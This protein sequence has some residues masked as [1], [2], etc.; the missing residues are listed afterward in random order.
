MA[1]HNTLS[2]SGTTLEVMVSEH[3]QT[4]EWLSSV[5]AGIEQLWPPFQTQLKTLPALNKLPI[6]SKPW[7]IELT[8][9][10]ND[11]I[12]A[13]NVEHRQQDKPTDVLTFS[14]FSDSTPELASLPE[15]ALGSIFISVSYAQESG[16]PLVPYLLERFFH[17]C[18]HL[19]G[20]H[21]D[22]MDDYH[23]VKG[24]Q[25]DLIQLWTETPCANPR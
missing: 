10:D 7:E 14:L 16:E 22:T 9:V 20:Q 19:L 11:E 3:L 23:L 6:H 1:E 25:T 2:L 4:T 8:F 13:L 5:L 15:I 12:Q 24:L 18:L 21:H 17:G